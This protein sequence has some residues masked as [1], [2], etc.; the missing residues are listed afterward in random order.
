MTGERGAFGGGVLGCAY[1]MAAVSGNQP[2]RVHEAAVR[3]N[4]NNYLSLKSVYAITPPSRALLDVICMA[5]I[6]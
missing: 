5:F 4:G 1:V 3:S 6:S 2:T